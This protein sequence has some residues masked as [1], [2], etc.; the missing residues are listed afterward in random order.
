MSTVP[1][2]FWDLANTFAQTKRLWSG[3]SWFVLSIFVF[4]AAAAAA[5]A[6]PWPF[7]GVGTFVVV[8]T[9]MITKHVNSTQEKILT[10]G[11]TTQ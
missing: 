7:V 6:L 4:T 1:Y 8:V 2:F 5:E 3:Q 11:P 10:N 9:Q